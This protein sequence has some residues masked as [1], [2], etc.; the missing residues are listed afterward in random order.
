MD[1]FKGDIVHKFG[2]E[3]TWLSLVPL[4]KQAELSAGN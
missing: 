2:A 1:V 4:E 3:S